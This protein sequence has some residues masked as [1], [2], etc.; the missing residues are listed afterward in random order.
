MLLG[1]ILAIGSENYIFLRDD[2][3]YIALLVSAILCCFSFSEFLTRKQYL[4][5][6]YN[7]IFTLVCNCFSAKVRN[8]FEISE[9][10]R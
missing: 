8:Y 9:S 5:L 6:I 10:N 4:V 1:S 7:V 2:R 3:S